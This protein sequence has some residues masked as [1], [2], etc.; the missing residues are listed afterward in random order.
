MV[1]MENF[2]ISIRFLEI[3][4][5]G[6]HTIKKW[7]TAVFSKTLPSTKSFMESKLLYTITYSYVE[8]FDILMPMEKFALKHPQNLPKSVVSFNFHFFMYTLI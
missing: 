7:S 1:L 6:Q 5:K 3:Y 8:N 4:F 2:E